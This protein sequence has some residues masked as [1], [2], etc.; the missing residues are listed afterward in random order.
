M[1]K[2]LQILLS[3]AALLAL[4]AWAQDPL[5]PGKGRAD[6]NGEPVRER[7]SAGRL[8][9]AAKASQVIGMAVENNQG[10]K[11]GKV[12]DMAVDV[13]SGRI[14]QVILS[15]G[16]V[17]GIGDHLMAVPPQVFR[18]DDTRKVLH[19]E[20]DKAKLLAGPKFEMSKWAECC[21]AEQL[22]RVYRHYGQESA[23]NFVLTGAASETK[24]GH[25]TGG[26]G[27]H[28]H[29]QKRSH[30][31]I[32]ASHLGR[33]QPATK[34]MGTAVKNLQHEELGKVEDLLVDLP[35]GRVVAVIVSSGGFLGLGEELSAIPPS[36]LHFTPDRK[37]LQLD[38]SREALSKAPHFK[39][40]EWPD[41]VQPGYATEVYRAYKVEPYFST[42]GTEVDNTRQNA[43]D[44][45]GRKLTPVDQ[46]NSPADVETT[47]LIRKK[48]VASSE[49]SVNAKNV[50]IITQNGHVT[51]RGPV[52]SA[53]E[54]RVIGEIAARIAKAG[55]VDNQLDVKPAASKD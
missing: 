39:A 17:L 20:A 41:F 26:V 29:P 52:N 47:A 10:E 46:G 34:V 42:T 12:E 50:K 31:L 43:R 54:K 22:A 5:N 19:V 21:D 11:L 15:T 38:T 27:D 24:S 36:A 30:T 33:V 44:R 32:P 3:T 16:G 45:D 28:P 25:T 6:Y 1:K 23:Y 18:R 4:P 49:L 37:G 8:H 13:E 2:K 35:S 40:S 55:Q 48:L 53:E 14:L 9:D 7:Q 51:L